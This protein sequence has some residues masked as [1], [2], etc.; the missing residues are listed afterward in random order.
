LPFF[1]SST[2]EWKDIVGALPCPVTLKEVGPVFGHASR[3]LT[4]WSL[5]QA[6]PADVLEVAEEL[7][8]LD[9]ELD[10]LDV[11]PEDVVSAALAALAAQRTMPTTA[12]RTKTH[13]EWTRFIP[14]LPHFDVIVWR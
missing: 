9:D 11:E 8:A 4:D 1:S 2:F 12:I 6:G 10:E 14:Y 7:E 13:T 3:F 5:T